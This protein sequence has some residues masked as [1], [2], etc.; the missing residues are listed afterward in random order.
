MLFQ[1]TKLV[2]MCINWLRLCL[3][4]LLLFVFALV[5][6]SVSVVSESVSVVLLQVLTFMLID[7]DRSTVHA[8]L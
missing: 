8:K 3:L 2:Q 5:S 4:L 1:K 7:I 6:V